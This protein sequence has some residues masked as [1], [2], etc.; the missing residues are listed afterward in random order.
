M[1]GRINK[2]FFPSFFM[3]KY[4]WNCPIC[5]KGGAFTIDISSTKR[6]VFTKLNELHD[7]ASSY[8]HCPPSFLNMEE[9]V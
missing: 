2:P 8:C 4:K 7:K 3:V 9:N 5:K 1:I 6:E